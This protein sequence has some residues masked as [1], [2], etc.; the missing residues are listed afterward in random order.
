MEYTE[1]SEQYAERDN[2]KIKLLSKALDARGNDNSKAEELFDELSVYINTKFSDFISNSGLTD[3]TGMLHR[4]NNIVNTY[5]IFV[6]YPELAGK[7]IIGIFGNIKQNN[8]LSTLLSSVLGANAGDLISI[9]H[10][11]PIVFLKEHVYPLALNNL[12][13]TETSIAEHEYRLLA[14]GFYKENNLDTRG[15][16]RAFSV[17]TNN[18]R[19]NTAI[20]FFPEDVDFENELVQGL[21]KTTNTFLLNINSRKAVNI[22]K[23]AFKIYGTMNQEMY[24]LHPC[25]YREELEIAENSLT[26]NEVWELLE[27]LTTPE[28][29]YTFTTE[30]STILL[31]LQVEL[32]EELEKVTRKLKLINED[33][34]N[35]T[36]SKFKGELKGIKD[37]LDNKKSNLSENII[38]LQAFSKEILSKTQELE[39]EFKKSASLKEDVDL[40][41]PL[42]KRKHLEENI[43]LLADINRVE[44][45]RDIQELIKMDRVKGEIFQAYLCKKRGI[46]VDTEA[47]KRLKELDENTAVI[48]KIKIAFREELKLSEKV[49][50]NLAALIQKPQTS[51][52]FYYKAQGLPVSK[53]KE[54]LAFLKRARDKG[55]VFA[56]Q[57]ML[58]IVN[59][60]GDSALLALADQM[61]PEA[62]YRIAIDAKDEKVKI[63]RLK[64]AASLGDIQAIKEIVKIFCEPLY[65]EENGYSSEDCSSIDTIIEACESLLEKTRD[66]QEKK[67]LNEKL[68]LLYKRSGNW[69][70]AVACWEKCDTGYAYWQLGL[71]YRKGND[72][73]GIRKNLTRAKLYLTKAEF[74]GFEEAV[75]LLQQVK[76]E[77]QKEM[78]KEKNRSRANREV[79]E[80][81]N[82]DTKKDPPPPKSSDG[83]ACFAPGTRIL[84]ADMTYCRVED[85][86][87]GDVAVVYD[88][89]SGSLGKG[90]IIANV[91]DIADK[92]EYKTITMNFENG[93]SLKIIKSHAL[94]DLT[95]KQYVWIDDKNVE[96]YLEHEFAVYFKGKISGTKLFDY[97]IETQMSYCYM[98]VSRYHLNVFAEDFLTMPP[99]KLTV[100]M[101]NIK[102]DMRYDLSVVEQVGKTSYEE[103][104][105]LISIEEY[106]NLPCEYL[107]GVMALN[108]CTI[109]DFEYALMLYRDQSQYNHSNGL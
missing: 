90:R 87:I 22:I 53:T 109:K 25:F 32:Q 19:K 83:G 80:N 37:V 39:E 100:N 14:Q 92:K 50:C 61:V 8:S 65:H 43:V 11:I 77:I 35:A 26:L 86:K 54:R 42:K 5:E 64:I 89:Y 96:T 3:K 91:H 97:S 16:V 10:K 4:L 55:H 71:I 94:F 103:I 44:A 56:E 102:N 106:S 47:L 38:K 84:M 45:E 70:N 78:K 21:F 23:Q 29:N 58:A 101:F 74:H 60:K 107:A 28:N 20:V 18:M 76:Q 12:Y 59:G 62:N 15:I 72:E 73:S 66:E 9:N 88:H 98:P 52:E 33:A 79:S 17:K 48:A 82:Y 46:P 13:E 63:A 105:N 85:I 67:E 108:R 68:G 2:K 31:Q 40:A 51:D 69:R 27:K 7:R 1:K 6:L 34:I 99:T 49:C 75:S 81:E 57:A 30:V 36:N 41:L 24:V 93:K 95:E 104:K